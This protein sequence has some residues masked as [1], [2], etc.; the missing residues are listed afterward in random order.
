LATTDVPPVLCPWSKRRVH[1]FG[2][3]KNDSLPMV[4]AMAH[5]GGIT[6]SLFVFPYRVIEVDCVPVTPLDF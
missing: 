6:T 2:S 3:S 5:G 4:D 1:D